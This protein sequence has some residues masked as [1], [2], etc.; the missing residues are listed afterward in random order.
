MEKRFAVIYKGKKVGT[1]NLE[2]DRRGKVVAR[3]APLPAFRPIARL[4]STVRKAKDREWDFEPETPSPGQVAE[5]DGA[6]AVLKA[7]Q[8]SL[9]EDDSGNAVD[10]QEI[11]LLSREPP[12]LRIVW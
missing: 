10:T 3:M 1:V 11:T 6:E 12:R 8:L 9:I 2:P 5:E 4:R 7:V